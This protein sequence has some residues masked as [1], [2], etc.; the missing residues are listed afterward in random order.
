MAV[1]Q[2]AK[3]RVTIW[4]NNSTPKDV[5]KKIED[6]EADTYARIHGGIFHNGQKVE[7]T[8]ISINKWMGKQS[9][10]NTH[11]R[12]LFSHKKKQFWYVLPHGYTLKI[13]C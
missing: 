4:P 10:I 12:I 2:K 3:D 7:M 8:Q 6:G 13:L 11:N 1:P 5:P 9:V